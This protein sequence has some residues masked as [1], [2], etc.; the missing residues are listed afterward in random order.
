MNCHARWQ[1]KEEEQCSLS[2]SEVKMDLISAWLSNWQDT[3]VALSWNLDLSKDSRE[4]ACILS[5]S[6]SSRP[7]LYCSSS[8]ALSS[9]AESWLKCSVCYII[10]S[11]A[12]F[13]RVCMCMIS[14]EERYMNP[15][16]TWQ[17]LLPLNSCW[18]SSRL[19]ETPVNVINSLTSLCF[20]LF[21]TSFGLVCLSYGSYFLSV[22][23]G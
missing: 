6:Y 21:G 10:L 15:Q 2:L 9:N 16:S 1:C 14:E 19:K 3:L 13:C 18:K 12:Y 7:F 23:V 20:P 17:L 8:F 22:D 4:R 5:I 11:S